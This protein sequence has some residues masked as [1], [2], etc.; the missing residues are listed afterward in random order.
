MHNEEGSVGSA[1][2]M[3]TQDY[4]LVSHGDHRNPYWLC[5]TARETLNL[6]YTFQHL[7][8][9]PLDKVAFPEFAARTRVAAAC[10][11]ASLAALSEDDRLG[12]SKNTV[13][14]GYQCPAEFF[15]LYSM[16]EVEVEAKKAYGLSSNTNDL[17]WLTRCQIVVQGGSNSGIASYSGG[18]RRD[19]SEMLSS[20]LSTASPEIQK[21]MLGV[22]RRSQAIA[23]MRLS[24]V[25]ITSWGHGDGVS[26]CVMGW[27]ESMC[28]G[29]WR[30]RGY[31][32]R[33]VG[34]GNIGTGMLPVPYDMSGMLPRDDVAVAMLQPMPITSL[35]Y[36]LAN[37]LPG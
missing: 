6:H 9:M 33:N 7:K 29:L 35:A 30:L 18:T 2:P 8:P 31:P 17:P 37:A 1:L 24:F 10:A 13:V 21:Q 34:Y 11:L 36:A 26:Q 32:G 25:E 28:H 27:S 19:G 16:V 20:M 4:A 5:F 23:M 22:V 12:A 14:D 15:N 3:V